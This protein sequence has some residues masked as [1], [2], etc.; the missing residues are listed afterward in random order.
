LLNFAVAPAVHS[1][2]KIALNITLS[3]LLGALLGIIFGYIAELMDRRVR[4]QEDII[5]LLKIPVFANI[6]DNSGRGGKRFMGL[7]RNMF[8]AV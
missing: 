6:R 1:S 7:K 8:K 4:S 5:E 3:I 2:P